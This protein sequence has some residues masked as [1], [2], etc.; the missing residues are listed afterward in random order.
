[1]IPGQRILL[2]A[3]QGAG[4]AIQF[5]RYGERLAEAGMIVQV[6]C[7]P[8]LERLFAAVPWID[9]VS[10]ATQPAFDTTCLIMSLPHRFAT[11]PM[12][13][14]ADLPYLAPPGQA[15]RAAEPGSSPRV[16]LVWAGT[17]SNTRDHWRSC[18]REAYSRL[19]TV[20]GITFQ[21]LQF[22]WRPEPGEDGWSAVE[23]LA[24]AVSDYAD[25]A[26]IIAQLDLIISVDT[27][28]AHLAGA[29]GK[30]VW[31]LLGRHAD[32]RWLLDRADTPWYPGMRLFRTRKNAGWD[33]L[34]AELARELQDYSD[35]W[36]G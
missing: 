25:T 26:A 36:H 29:L 1:L 7:Q 4:D 19:L 32:W 13:I 3:E 27:S 18:P 11:D 31:M 22:G 5:I 15:I 30:P 6:H 2:V 24:P 28:V 23:P 17:P 34:L 14:P 10:T 16:G 33:A 12:T 8:G 21:S 35:R 20:S 9:G